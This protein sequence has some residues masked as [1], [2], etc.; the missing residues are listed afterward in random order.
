V[1]AGADHFYTAARPEL[2]AQIESWL[3]HLN[4]K[5]KI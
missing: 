2:A 5:S 3:R 1:I 4:P